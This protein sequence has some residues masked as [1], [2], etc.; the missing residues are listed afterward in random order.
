MLIIGPDLESVKENNLD[1][2][3][4]GRN[5]VKFLGGNCLEPGMRKD[6]NYNLGK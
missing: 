1:T 5:R 3:E 4:V 2:S 6:T